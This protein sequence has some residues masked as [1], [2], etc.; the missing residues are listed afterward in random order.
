MST[1][2]QNLRKQNPKMN[3]FLEALEKNN[4]G[5]ADTLLQKLFEGAKNTESKNSPSA[6]K[7]MATANLSEAFVRLEERG[8]KINQV[9]LKTQDMLD[10]AQ[11]FAKTAKDLRVQQQNSWF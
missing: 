5:S 4:S 2:A 7:E 9:L 8:V 3:A 10:A 6:A 11:Q 1:E